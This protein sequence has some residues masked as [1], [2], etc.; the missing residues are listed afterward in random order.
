MKKLKQRIEPQTENCH[1]GDGFPCEDNDEKIEDITS[2]DPS[3]PFD[4]ARRKS[5]AKNYNPT[6]TSMN[7][8]DAFKD[9]T[10]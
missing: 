10:R 2:R 3:R 1:Y 6:G 5:Y 8:E 7:D 4:S 9:K